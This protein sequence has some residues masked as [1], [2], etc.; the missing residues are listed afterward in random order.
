MTAYLCFGEIFVYQRGGSC[1]KVAGIVTQ[2][3]T[4]KVTSILQ[5]K[6]GA[7]KGDLGWV[8]NFYRLIGFV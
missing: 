2:V 7:T 5:R 6:L 3:R 4:M 8:S 1:R